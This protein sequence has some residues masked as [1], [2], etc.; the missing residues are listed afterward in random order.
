MI[1]LFSQAQV[2]WMSGLK[3]YG[4]VGVCLAFFMYSTW[5]HNEQAA[6]RERAREAR[7]QKREEQL[8]RMIQVVQQQREEMIRVVQEQMQGIVQAVHHLTRALSIE[9]LTRPNLSQRTETEITEIKEET[10]NRRER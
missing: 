3:P 6:A 8:E 7:E 2:D 5:R 4:A 9:V 10:Q 1:D